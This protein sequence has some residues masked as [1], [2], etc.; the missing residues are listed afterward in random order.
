VWLSVLFK[1]LLKGPATEAFPLG[2][3]T[4]TPKRYRG[5]AM[6][7]AS[8]CS[9]C[10]TCEYVCAGGAIHFEEQ[11]DGLHFTLWHNTCV[12]CGMCEQ[13][14]MSKA[15]HL[16]ND[17]HL[18]H[19]QD[20]KYAMVEQGTVPYKP[21]LSCGKQMLPT[22]APLMELAYRGDSLR[23]AELRQLCPD[24]RRAASAGGKR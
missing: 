19:T 13:N 16:S 15:I 23:I 7:D 2:E 14:C 11:S 24:C 6:F 18:A 1:N 9:G 12:F 10:R 8:S 5:R 21:C 22:P 3:A 4:A 20:K 17:W